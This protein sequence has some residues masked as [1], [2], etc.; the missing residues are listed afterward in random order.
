MEYLLIFG[1]TFI[2]INLFYGK[3]ETLQDLIYF[4]NNQPKKMDLR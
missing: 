1:G 4:L 3:I 2:F